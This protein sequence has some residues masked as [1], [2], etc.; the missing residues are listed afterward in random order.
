[1]QVITESDLDTELWTHQDRI[2]SGVVSLKLPNTYGLDIVNSNL[3]ILII[4]LT[5][6]SALMLQEKP[7]IGQNGEIGYTLY[8]CCTKVV[9]VLFKCWF[10]D[11]Y[12]G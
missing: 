8:L 7:F 11:K 1:M 10:L 12:R 6:Y 4:V 3:T 5:V 2:H 9:I